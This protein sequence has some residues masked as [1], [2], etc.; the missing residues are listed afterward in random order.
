MRHDIQDH[1]HD[2]QERNMSSLPNQIEW[3]LATVAAAFRIE[4]YAR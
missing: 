3:D 2:T 4:L 1:H